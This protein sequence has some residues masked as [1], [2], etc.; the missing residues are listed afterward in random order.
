MKMKYIFLII[1]MFVFILFGCDKTDARLQ[2]IYTQNSKDRY[3]DESY[4]EVTFNK[5]TFKRY[6]KF[7]IGGK[8]SEYNFEYK[9]KIIF[10][11]DQGGS[12]YAILPI[13][14]N[15]AFNDPSKRDVYG[16]TFSGNKLTLEKESKRET[17][18]RK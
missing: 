13:Y 10:T 18:T 17:Y 12:F 5:N 14:E 1:V 6:S 16:Y 7:N 11:N 8:I 4:A 3:G 9:I 2:G 15:D